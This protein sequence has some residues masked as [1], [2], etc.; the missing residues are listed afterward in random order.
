LQKNWTS[1][2]F[3]VTIIIQE[4]TCEQLHALLDTD[5]GGIG[6]T[7]PNDRRAAVEARHRYRLPC[8]RAV[9]Q[10]SFSGTKHGGES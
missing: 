5:I 10:D 1:K 9:Y 8:D 2:A 7:V 4:F 6:A 3:F